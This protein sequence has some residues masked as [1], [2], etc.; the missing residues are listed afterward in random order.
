GEV[1]AHQREVVPVIEVADR[2]DPR[3]AVLVA[4]LAAQRVAGIRRV[5]DHATRADDISDLDDRAPLRAGRM[6]VEVPGHATSLGALC[7]LIY[8]TTRSARQARSRVCAAM[9]AA[10]R[11]SRP[12]KVCAP[13]RASSIRSVISPKVASTRLRHSAM[14]F[15][16]TGGML[17][18]WSLAGGTRTAVPRAAWEAANALPLNPLSASRSRGGGPASSRPAATSRSFTAA[19]TMLQARTMRLE[20]SVLIASRKP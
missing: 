5:G 4:E 1:P 17:R 10:V 11:V 14:I 20:R 16:R 7:V 18:R 2:P 12:Q 8:P 13:W 6:D 15:C 19:G 9:T 3:D